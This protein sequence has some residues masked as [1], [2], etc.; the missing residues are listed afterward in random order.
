MAGEVQPL[1]ARFEKGLVAMLAV[2]VAETLNKSPA[3]S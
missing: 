3:Q 2:A 1:D